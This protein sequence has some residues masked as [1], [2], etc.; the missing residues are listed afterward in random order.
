MAID[1]AVQNMNVQLT[2]FFN[3]V[4]KVEAIEEAF[5]PFMVHSK[6]NEQNKLDAYKEELRSLFSNN[7]GEV[8]DFHLV[9]E[10][11][12]KHFVSLL[13]GQDNTKHCKVLFSLLEHVASENVISTR[14]LCEALLSA[15]QLSYKSKEY[16]LG[17]FSLVKRMITNVEYKGVREIMKMAIEKSSC[18]PATLEE[19]E[20]PQAKALYELVEYIFDRNACLLPGYFVINEILKAYPENRHWP[21]WML[22]PLLSGFV[23]SFRP[24]A[25]MVS[26]MNR[27]NLLPVVDQTGPSGQAVSGWKLEPPTLRFSIKGNLPYTNEY[28]QPQSKLLRYVLEQPY[29][30][31]MVCSMLGLQKQHKQRCMVLENELVNLIVDAMERHEERASDSPGYRHPP[32]HWQ[33]LS[34]QLIFFVLFQFSSFPHMVL[35]FINKLSGKKIQKAR[36]HLMWALL[37]FISGSIQTNP[38][39]DFLPVLKLYDLLYPEREPLP[40]PDVNDPLSC[41]QMA[42]VCIWIHLMKKA[43]LEG[44]SVH[45]P[46]P[47]ALKT[48]HEYLQHFVL[49]NS[50]PLTVGTDYRVALLCNAFSTNQEYFPR[51]MGALVDSL[52]AHQKIQTQMPG[53]N[54]VAGGPATPLPMEILDALT[55]HAKMSLIHSIATH[56]IKLVQTK[57]TLALAPA[58]VETYSRLLVYT[59]IESLGIK[60]FIAIVYIT[61]NPTIE[62]SYSLISIVFL[63]SHKLIIPSFIFGLGSMELQPQGQ[64]SRFLSEPKS[65]VSSESEEL[66]RALI[67]TLARA[68]HITG[69]ESV[70]GPWY[71]EL[72]MCVQT[73]TPLTWPSHTLQC[74]PP[75]LAEIYNNSPTTLAK[76]VKQQI[77]GVGKNWAKST[78][79]R[80]I[81]AVNDLIWKY[82]I[83][84]IDRFILCLILRNHEEREAQVCFLII[85]FLLVRYTD[86]QTRVTEFVHDNSPEHWKLSNWHEKHLAFHS[87]YQETFAPEGLLDQNAATLPIYFGNICLRFLPVFD[88][89]I[90]RYLEIAPMVSVART[91]DLLLDSIGSLYKFHDHPVTYLYNTLHYYERRLSE[92]HALK[93]K[94]VS[95]ILGSGVHGL[96][97]LSQPMQE[98]LNFPGDDT[99][100]I[101]ELDYYAKIV[102]RF[103]QTLLGKE[104]IFDGDWRFHEFP[105]ASAHALYITCTELMSLPVPAPTVGSNLIDVILRGHS[106]LPRGV[107]GSWINGVGLILTSLPE[108]YWQVLFD[109]ILEFLDSPLMTSYNLNVDPF[110]LFDFS[111]AHNTL[112]HVQPAYLLAL[113]HSILHHAVIRQLVGLPQFLKEKVCPLVKTE[114]QLL[115]ICHLIGPSLRRLHAECTRALMDLTVALYQLLQQV[116]KCQQ[117]LRFM[118]TICDLLYPFLFS[119]LMGGIG[120]QKNSQPDRFHTSSLMSTNTSS[121]AVVLDGLRSCLILVRQIC[122]LDWMNSR[123]HIKYMFTGYMVESHVEQIIR[124]LR[125][126][127][128]KRLRFI[129][130]SNTEELGGTN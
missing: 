28:L 55:V 29:S 80:C 15:D 81:E 32:S 56:V 31:D 126:A 76:D 25:Q 35:E 85:Q 40:V 66:N 128:Q 64:L 19:S 36:D 42:P 73:S 78:V 6:E 105:N 21:H 67:L 38:L 111:K 17:S 127:L 107:L 129:T 27:T 117:V 7:Q 84:P 119:H 109:R 87:N 44:V 33:H 61:F 120:G 91:L 47:I 3:D 124:M 130:H 45:R 86:F 75:G 92:R 90:H 97:H 49:N 65:I 115:W 54:C 94:L 52:H 12:L 37:Q 46:L 30:R 51:P 57:S 113:S 5:A 58:L 24:T 104:S 74:F 16:W 10:A 77:K 96:S 102:H 82:H 63:L 95:V 2:N 93:K 11:S 41:H 114:E 59:E 34:A 108:P 50:P 14:S 60:G 118:D 98:Y 4:L 101:P 68:V 121:A 43:Q 99:S 13:S 39:S 112:T 23:D 48:H 70:S 110:Q 26:L 62:Y 106:A 88:M 69:G 9:Q 116:D 125:P 20:V 8:Q 123:Y 22:A 71:K 83:F 103:V 18:L 79:N 89:V 1:I 100:W 122:T 53:T 72:V